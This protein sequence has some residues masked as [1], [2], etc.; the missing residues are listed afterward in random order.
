MGF[1]KEDKKLRLKVEAF[2]VL[3]L[4]LFMLLVFGITANKH[5]KKIVID[6]DEQAGV[7]LNTTEDLN[8]S[9]SVSSGNNVTSEASNN[10][11]SIYMNEDK[12]NEYIEEIAKSD[13]YSY[14]LVNNILDTTGLSEYF[15][16]AYATNRV[17]TT[18]DEELKYLYKYNVT[19]YT[20]GNEY[21]RL[22]VTI[23]YG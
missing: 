1:N 13:E 22:D 9:D 4:I 10:G 7:V 16:P 15:D 20:D 6:S 11:A 18:Y 3:A 17:I 8:N 12:L 21:D 23:E 2:A 19:S 5:N 14:E